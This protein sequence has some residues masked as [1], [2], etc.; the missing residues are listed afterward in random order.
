MPSHTHTHYSCWDLCMLPHHQQQ[1]LFAYPAWLKGGG[2]GGRSQQAADLD[3]NRE[4]TRCPRWETATEKFVHENCCRWS[5]SF[6]DEHLS[7]RVPSG[8]MMVLFSAWFLPVWVNFIITRRAVKELLEADYSR[9]EERFLF[10]PAVLFCFLLWRRFG[11]DCS[12]LVKRRQS[13]SSSPRT[14]N[15]LWSVRRNGKCG[16]RDVCCQLCD[17]GENTTQAAC[18]LSRRMKTSCKRHVVRV[19][20][21]PIDSGAVWK[22]IS[23]NEYY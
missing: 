21:P 4:L 1:T 12:E 23:A 19:L 10:L 17:R 9:A 2:G 18:F 22:P 13:F 5:V 8:D 11:K 6:T 14:R 20:T 3:D 16:H 15:S 7:V